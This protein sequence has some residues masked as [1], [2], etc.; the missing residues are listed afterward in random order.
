VHSP[1][2]S[3]CCRSIQPLFSLCRTTSGT[4]QHLSFYCFHRKRRQKLI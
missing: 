2:P 3:A 1:L 4:I